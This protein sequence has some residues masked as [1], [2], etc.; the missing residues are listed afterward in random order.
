VPKAVEEV[1][2]EELSK[3]S[4]LDNH[5]PEFRYQTYSRFYISAQAV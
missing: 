1:I 2:D 4:Y 5:S 3:L